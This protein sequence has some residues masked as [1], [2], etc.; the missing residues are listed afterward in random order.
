MNNKIKLKLIIAIILALLSIIILI[1]YN[2]TTQDAETSACISQTPTQENTNNYESNDQKDYQLGLNYYK[3]IM[4]EQ[5]Y[6]KAVQ[7]FTNAADHNNT[8]AMV[9]LADMYATGEGVKEDKDK[10]FNYLIQAAKLGNID[11]T[12]RLIDIYTISHN[13]MSNSKRDALIEACNEILAHEYEFDEYYISH[14]KSLLADLYYE[15]ALSTPQLNV[16]YYSKSA[17][18]GHIEASYQLAELYKTGDYGP[19]RKT[20]AIDIYKS[21]LKNKNNDRYADANYALCL[22][23]IESA[24]DN[25]S[26]PFIDNTSLPFKYC[27]EAAHAGNPDA[28]YKTG[29]LCNARKIK[30][31]VTWFEQAAAQNQ[32]DAQLAL[33]DIAY[34]KK[35]YKDALDWY[36]KAIENGSTD[37]FVKL[38]MLYLYGYGVEPNPGVAMEWFKKADKLNNDNAALYIGKMYEEGIGVKINKTEAF[39][40]YNRA[41]KLGNNNDA[42]YHLGRMLANG[43]GVKRDKD[44]AFKLLLKALENGNRQAGDEIHRLYAR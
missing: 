10:S 9:M 29:L 21:I 1:T 16:Q 12:N 17:S 26:L 18:L 28:Q 8:D 31:A 23:Y 39:K 30:C 7:L 33:G 15:I 22:L 5:N 19:Q 11:A 6:A 24:P 27:I 36:S 13:A 41:Y 32:P 38:G 2:H 4:V 44:I 14:I 43:I 35:L 34:E 20:E 3:G 37:A 42:P 40:W 25:T